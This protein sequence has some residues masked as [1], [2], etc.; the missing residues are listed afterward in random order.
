MVIHDYGCNYQTF[1]SSAV[2][3]LYRKSPWRRPSYEKKQSFNNKYHVVIVV[4]SF[5]HFSA[6]RAIKE[7][8]YS[9]RELI[10][11]TNHCQ[12]TFEYV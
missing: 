6:L 1:C 10:E 8:N 2:L 5:S 12:V 11:L 9:C 3:P 7:I 4:S